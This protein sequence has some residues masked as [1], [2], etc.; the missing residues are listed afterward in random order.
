M[1]R[2]HELAGYITRGGMNTIPLEDARG[3]QWTK[4]IFQR[5]DQSGGSADALHHG[6]ATR[7][8]R[9]ANYLRR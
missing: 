7:F 5:G 1:D 6:A 9:Q 2:V 3:A 4:L 8:H